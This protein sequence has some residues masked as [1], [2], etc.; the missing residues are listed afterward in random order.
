MALYIICRYINNIF[1]CLSSFHYNNCSFLASFPLMKIKKPNAS[2][3]VERKG[4]KILKSE[5]KLIT[6]VI[7]D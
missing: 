3:K 5:H 6:E 4:G 7:Y 1:T 2:L